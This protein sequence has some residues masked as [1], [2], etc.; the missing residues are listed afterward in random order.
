MGLDVRS[1]H[2][3]HLVADHTDNEHGDELRWDQQKAELYARTVPP[4]R[5]RVLKLFLSIALDNGA[6]VDRI[7]E[8]PCLERVIGGVLARVQ[9]VALLVVIFV[10]I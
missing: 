9:V 2:L 1:R 5:R 6:P 8:A 3:E 7:F 10:V 4:R